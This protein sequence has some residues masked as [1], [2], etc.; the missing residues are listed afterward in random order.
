[1]IEPKK[2]DFTIYQG[3]TWEHTYKVVDDAGAVVVL[4]GCTA[5]LHSRQEPGAADPPLLDLIGA[6][7]ANNGLV[8]FVITPDLTIGQTW[9]KIGFDAELVWPLPS[10][11]VDKLAYGTMKLIQE[12]TRVVTP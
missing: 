7:D 8:Q 4:T 9:E 2:Q 5:R 12:Y 10:T 6:V 11:K 1:M 3:A